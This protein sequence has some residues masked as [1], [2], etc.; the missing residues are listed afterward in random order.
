[1]AF[2]AGLTPAQAYER[3]INQSLAT[4][5][6]LTAQKVA[7]QAATVSS[8]VPLAVIGHFW[9]V[10]PMMT[11]WAQTPG[12]A[13][14]A[15]AQREDPAFEV[16]A[17]WVTLRDAMISARDNLIALFPANANGFALYQSFT[18][19]GF[20]YRDFTA[21]Q[22]APALPLLDSVIAAT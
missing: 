2:N 17:Q 4:R 22:C 15:K 11:A 7:L 6:Y 12:V 16:A 5:E 20:T 21:A 14:Y 19:T 9:N 13:A 8:L 1:M 10:I 3:L 18:S